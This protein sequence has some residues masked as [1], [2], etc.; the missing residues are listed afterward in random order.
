VETVIT[1][2]FN[3]L[4]SLKSGGRRLVEREL[5]RRGFDTD[6]VK[7]AVSKGWIEFKTSEKQYTEVVQGSMDQWRRSDLSTAESLKLY[8]SMYDE[9]TPV[10][11]SDQIFLTGRNP[12]HAKKQ[13]SRPSGDTM[14]VPR[15]NAFVKKANRLGIPVTSHEESTSFSPLFQFERRRPVPPGFEQINEDMFARKDNKFMVYNGA[16]M[17]KW[18]GTQPVTK[19][20]TPLLT[21]LS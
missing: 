21:T 20:S 5:Q 9:S 11:T 8:A 12:P 1:E 10:S 17:R 18:N 19:I 4:E 3:G 15:T 6:G 13:S 14:P 7:E 16:G 2:Q